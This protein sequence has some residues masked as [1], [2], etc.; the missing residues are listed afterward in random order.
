M[1]RNPFIFSVTKNSRVR[2]R[3]ETHLEKAGPVF[4]FFKGRFGFRGSQGFQNIWMPWGVQRTL[5]LTNV[6]ALFIKSKS[7]L[8]D[9]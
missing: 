8:S 4:K 7:F 3:R 9:S 6:I 5:S 1:N 2:I